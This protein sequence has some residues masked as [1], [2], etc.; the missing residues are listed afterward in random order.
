MDTYLKEIFFKIFLFILFLKPIT[1]SLMAILVN[2]ITGIDIWAYGDFEYYTQNNIIGPNFLYGTFI[3]LIGAKSL[4]DT[5]LVILA[6]FISIII[7]TICIYIFII[8]FKLT[9]LAIAMYLLFSLHPYFSYYTF[10]LD[11]LIFSKLACALFLYGLLTNQDRKIKFLNYMLL[12][13]SMFRASS[14]I[15]LVSI[16]FN[17]SKTLFKKQKIHLLIIVILSVITITIN[18]SYFEIMLSSKKEFGWSIEYTKT[19]FGEFGSVIDIIIHYTSRVFVLFGGRESLYVYKFSY[20]EQAQFPNFELFIFIFFVCFHLLCLFS[21]VTYSI[22]KN[23]LIPVLV[24][25]LMLALSIFTVGHMRY[26]ISY[27]PFILLGWLYIGSVK[28]QI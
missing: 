18:Y 10:K 13:L 5:I 22:K 4:S 7:D 16:V 8:N 2:Y 17:N 28:R 15:F 20:F 23:I 6:G 12:L 11:T 21:F 19:I 25:L 26:L 27:Y 24:A 9:K 14:L 1:S 3:S